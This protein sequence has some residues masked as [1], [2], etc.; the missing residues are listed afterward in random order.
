[1]ART[2]LVD[3]LMV[4]TSFFRTSSSPSVRKVMLVKYSCAYIVLP[5]GLGTLD[6]LLKPPR[7]CNAAKSGHSRWFW[8]DTNSGEVCEISCCSWWS[9]ESLVL[10][11]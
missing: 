5:G 6:E 7:C 9:R 8:W 10:K 1:M 2:R 11:R 3:P 4:S